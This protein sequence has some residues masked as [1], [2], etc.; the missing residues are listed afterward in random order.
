M[1]G[2]NNLASASKEYE[3]GYEAAQAW[4]DGYLAHVKKTSLTEAEAEAASREIGHTFASQRINPTEMM[5]KGVM[6]AVLERVPGLAEKEH[7]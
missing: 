3:L 6:A 4:L 5:V 1:R 7:S 2:I